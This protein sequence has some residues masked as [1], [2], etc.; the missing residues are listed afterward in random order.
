[1]NIL[2]IDDDLM[3]HKVLNHSL[4]ALGHKII[5]ANNGQKALDYLKLERDIDIIICDM[6][7]PQVSGAEFINHLK[8][9]YSKW[10]PV[11]VVISSLEKGNEIL[12]NTGLKF[13]YFIQKPFEVSDLTGIIEH[14]QNSKK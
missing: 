14:I 10:M 13:N 1:M 5:S 8:E 3:I 6:I 11:I 7:M 12:N 4:T 9:Y 2:L